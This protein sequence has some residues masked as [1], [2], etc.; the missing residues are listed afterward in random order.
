MKLLIRRDFTTISEIEAMGLQ[1]ALSPAEERL[2]KEEKEQLEVWIVDRRYYVVL[3]FLFEGW[4]PRDVARL[5][6]EELEPWIAE[7]EQTITDWKAYQLLYKPEG[8]ES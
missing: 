3:P 7:I 2:A 6:Q 1:A 4:T 8:E 5:G